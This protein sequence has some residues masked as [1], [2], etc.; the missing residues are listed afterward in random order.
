MEEKEE[1]SD[2]SNDNDNDSDNVDE[3]P[4]KSRII[5]VACGGGFS[6]AIS[7]SG[8]LF[9]WGVCARG[10]L[11]KGDLRLVFSV[12]IRTFILIYIGYPLQMM[13]PNSLEG[14]GGEGEGGGK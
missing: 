6:M 8:E 1:S 10:R 4:P 7:S 3:E 2:R 14:E 9:S 12:Y 11:G 5:Q 13:L